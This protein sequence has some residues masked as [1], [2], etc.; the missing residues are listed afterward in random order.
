[1][2]RCIL[3]WIISAAKLGKNYPV[4]V[5][6][7]SVSPSRE[8]FLDASYSMIF[9]VNFSKIKSSSSSSL[10]LEKRYWS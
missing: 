4:G 7:S 6:A 5:N 10:N 8:T 3:E 2:Q 1:M 9:A